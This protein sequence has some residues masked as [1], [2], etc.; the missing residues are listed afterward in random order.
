MIS[1]G[2]SGQMISPVCSTRGAPSIQTSGRT[3]H[4][5]NSIRE[6]CIFARHDLTRDPPFS[7][8]DLVSCRNVLIYLGAGAQQRVLPA[9]HYSLKPSGL[10]ILGSAETTLGVDDKWVRSQLGTTSVYRL[11]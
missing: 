11:S 5:I 6:S 2:F 9:L 1:T 10:L 3:T 8:L 7:Q 4:S